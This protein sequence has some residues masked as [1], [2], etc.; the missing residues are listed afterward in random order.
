MSLEVRCPD[1]HPNDPSAKF[2]GTCGKK[3]VREPEREKPSEEPEKKT[4]F[5]GVG[6]VGLGILSGLRAA[7]QNRPEFGFVGVD[8]GVPRK[9]RQI[10]DVIRAIG[11]ISGTGH[12]WK[13]GERAIDEDLG[14]KN[15]LE[16]MEVLRAKSLFLFCS[17]GGGTGSGAGP[18]LFFQL[19]SWG[20]LGA[21]LALAVLPGEN[22]PEQT[23][24]NAY[25]GVSRFLRYR[26]RKTTDML[27][28]VGNSDLEQ[29]KAVDRHG[30]E[31]SGND[32]LVKIVE[33]IAAN[34]DL[35]AR[36]SININDLIKYGRSM[37]VIHFAPCLALSHSLKIYKGL[38]GVLESA[39]ARP[40]F[41][42][43]RDSALFVYLFLRLSK[44][45]K[46]KL[47]YEEILTEFNLWRQRNLPSSTISYLGIY[48]VDDAMDKV[49]ALLLVGGY[50][51]EPTLERAYEG[52]SRLKESTTISVDEL[53]YI[54]DAIKE[55]SYNLKAIY[56][57]V[58]EKPG[59]QTH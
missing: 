11:S 5:A 40:L 26:G 52:Y 38:S 4:C 56:S 32:I 9:E 7:I 25:C 47:K 8:V 49:D 45:L 17:L 18:Y 54:E 37:N 23:H 1:G 13:D 21:R 28:L 44:S 33:M 39:F 59:S 30:E 6:E 27:I 36:R 29:Y 10:D 53:S 48:Y 55:Y 51:L 24:F 46:A 15:Y 50:P 41:P 34:E 20:H 19:S 58:R 2:C 43:D 14:L 42:L 3:I 57:K 31:M 12:L 22:E 35:E 16:E